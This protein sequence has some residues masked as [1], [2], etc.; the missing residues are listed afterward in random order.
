[1][2]NDIYKEESIIKE[3][4]MMDTNCGRSHLPTNRRNISG[5]GWEERTRGKEERP[6]V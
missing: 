4:T 6:T 1:M 5:R 2:R 3:D